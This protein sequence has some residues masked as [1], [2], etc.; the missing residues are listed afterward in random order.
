MQILVFGQLKD[1]VGQSVL[2]IDHVED[3]DL[4]LQHLLAQYPALR[5]FSFRI[6]VDG[7][8]IDGKMPLLPGS[9][10]A[11]LPPFSGG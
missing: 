9:T 8:M 5:A 4:L 10:I 7:K 11:L 1:G 2:Q 6:A 3:T